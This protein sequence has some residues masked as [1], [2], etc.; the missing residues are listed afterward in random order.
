MILFIEVLHF[1]YKH[2]DFGNTMKPWSL[3]DIEVLRQFY[4]TNQSIKSIAQTLEPTP[5][6]VNKALTRFK[7]RPYH[8]S[9]YKSLCL[10][11]IKIE[12]K[13]SA[14]IEAILDY[15]NNVM[16]IALMVQKEKFFLDQRPVT[17]NQILFKVNYHRMK[18][19]L[20]IFNVD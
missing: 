9:Q 16:K 13:K 4:L 11:R 8:G 17:K 2:V 19:H 5:T 3:K 7:I 1:I 14:P 10:N 20:P 15:A 18:N 6:A 12:S